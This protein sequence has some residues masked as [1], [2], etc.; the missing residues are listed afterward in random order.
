MKLTLIQQFSMFVIVGTFRPAV[1]TVAVGSR[2]YG[3]VAFYDVER[4][5]PRSI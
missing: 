1:P 5:L 2:A 3:R 4:T